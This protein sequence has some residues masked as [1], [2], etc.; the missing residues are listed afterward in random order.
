LNLVATSEITPAIR[1]WKPY[2]GYKHSGVEWLGPIPEHWNVSTLKLL[3][4]TVHR[5]KSPDYVEEGGIPV[6]NQ[7]CVYWE[8]LRLENIKYDS[9]KD[10][11][12]GKGRLFPGDV[13]VNSTGTGT[14]GRASVFRHEETHLADGHVTVVRV[15][16]TAELPEYFFYLLQTPIYQGFI[17][18]ALVSGSTN[19]IELS[20]E[21]FRATPT[22][23]P[24][25]NEQARIVWFLDRETAKIDVLVAKKERLIELLQEKRAA[26]I[27]RAVT[28]G[29]DPHV[30]MKDSGIEWLGEIPAHWEMKGLRHVTRINQGLQIAQSARFSEPGPNRFEYITVKSIHAGDQGNKEYIENPPRSVICNPEDI[31]LAR[32]GATGEV[33]SGQLGAFHNNF[34]K[35]EYDSNQVNR[36]YLIY[37]LTNSLIKEHFLLLAGTT[38][39]P[40]L[41]HGEFLATPFVGPPIAEQL[42]IANF[43]DSEAAKVDT[44][45]AKIREG[46]DKLK[47]Y[48]TAL[49][50]GAV[51]GKIDVREDVVA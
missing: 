37:Y 5:G 44:L 7:A 36:R 41:N 28:K 16:Q 10:G 19:Q 12:D 21:S 39:I 30:P 46:I 38:T 50:S 20:R 9:G 23:V 1:K 3:A 17:Y 43:L 29:L 22:I 25:I 8:G 18:A 31:L 48:R 11:N 35:V 34:F 14:L 27:T 26:L 33:I 47:E 40:D 42:G 51:T 45:I 15:D 49:I 4:P 6:I 13:L 24:P 2:P 32:T